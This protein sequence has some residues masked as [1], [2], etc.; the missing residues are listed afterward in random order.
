VSTD[1]ARAIR[2]VGVAEIGR[3]MLGY[4]AR[5]ATHMANDASALVGRV[6]V[7]VNAVADAYALADQASRLERKLRE[8][9]RDFDAHLAPIV[10]DDAGARSAS[11]ER[12][13]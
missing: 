8:M 10:A 6:V 13:H 11:G 9:I 3:D 2:A 7:G 5:D 12:A 1:R 4:A